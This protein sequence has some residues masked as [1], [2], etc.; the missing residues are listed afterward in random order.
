RPHLP[1]VRP[2]HTLLCPHLPASPWAS[3]PIARRRRHRSHLPRVRSRPAQ[4]PSAAGPSPSASRRLPRQRP[5]PACLP[6]PAA[7]LSPLRPVASATSTSDCL[8]RKRP[9]VPSA[10]G[11]LLHAAQWAKRGDGPTL[12][13]EVVE[14]RFFWLPLTPT[15]LESAISGTPALELFRFWRLANGAVER[16]V[17]LVMERCQKGPKSWW[18]C[19]QQIGFVR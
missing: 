8:R 14:S 18:C 2:H 10:D 6:T 13:D 1:P 12:D 15:T 19:L 9:C 17:E 7:G 16:L 3:G 11:L 4:S 5:P